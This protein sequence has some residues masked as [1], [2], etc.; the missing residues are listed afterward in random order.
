ME[1]AKKSENTLIDFIRRA[2]AEHEQSPEYAEARNARRYYEGDNTTIAGHK[3]LIYDE[4]GNKY[5]DIWTPN[6]KLASGFFTMAVNQRQSFLLANGVSFND[7]ATKD[8][9]GTAQKPFDTQISL[10]MTEALIGGVSWT[11]FNEDHCEIFEREGFK[12]FPDEDDGAIKAGLRVWRLADDKPRVVYLFEMDGYTIFKEDRE[13]RELSIYKP[14]RRYRL[15]SVRSAVM[16]EIFDGEPYPAFPIIP[17]YANR[18]G[19]SLLHG[20]QATIDALDT[21]RSTQVN[22]VDSNLLYFLFEGFEGMGGFDIVKAISDLRKLHG[23]ATP[24]A[25]DNARITPHTVEAPF[26]GTRTTIEEIK[27]QL[28][29]DFSVFNPQSVISS[30]DTATAIRAAYELLNVATNVFEVQ[31]LQPYVL[32]I[33][34]LA[35]I[36]DEKPTFKRD[37]ITNVQEQMQTLL[38]LAPYVDEQYIREA[39]MTLLGDIDKIEEVSSRMEADALARLASDTNPSQDENLQEGE[40][41][42]TE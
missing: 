17:L 2:I 15:R 23:L 27:E 20:K 32:Q 26:E 41:G 30:S 35:G 4:M 31:Q 1:E 25:D 7:D 42:Q 5:E 13:T 14:F 6:H 28:N 24:P 34:E 8:R 22:N 10:A 33:L 16:E 3:H 12:P 36:K 19:T 38:M 29:F 40:N 9:L 21:G 18:R 39:G 11:F 37:A